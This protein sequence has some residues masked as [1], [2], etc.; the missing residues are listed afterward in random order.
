MKVLNEGLMGGY[1]GKTALRQ[2]SSLTFPPNL[3]GKIVGPEEK[4]FSRVFHSSYF[5][6]TPKQRKTHFS[7]PFSILYFPSLL[8]S[9]QPNIVLVTNIVE[10]YNFSLRLSHTRILMC[11]KLALGIIVNNKCAIGLAYLIVN[12]NYLSFLL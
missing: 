9:I 3:G 4:I 8:K 7:T 6:P 1:Y 12:N 2:F 10:N 5:L 11:T